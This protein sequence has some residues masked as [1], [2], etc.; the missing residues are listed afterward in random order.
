MN[1]GKPNQTGLDVIVA[2]FAGWVKSVAEEFRQIHDE[3]DVQ[4]LE[5]QVRS[6]GRVIQSRLVQHVLQEAV[7]RQQEATRICPYCGKRRR[8]QGLRRRELRTSLGEVEVV[9]IYWKCE[10]CGLCSH[11]AEGIIPESFSRLMRG[12]VCLV[13]TA[14]AS[15][16]KAELVMTGVLGATLDAETIRRRCQ[17]EGWALVRQADTPPQAV[18]PGKDLIGS[19]DGTTVRTRETGWREV[20]GYRF[21]HEGGRYGG[22]YLEKV[23]PFSSRVQQAADRLEQAQ[24]AR[25]VFLSDMAEWIKQMVPRQLPGWRHIA[26]YWHACQHIH[27]AGEGLYGQHHPKAR[28]WSG[29]WSRRLRG[30][31]ANGVA[32]KMRR[33]VLHYPQLEKQTAFLELIRFVDKHAELMDYQA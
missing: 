6:G 8:H 24:A 5:E 16:E 25:K 13:G 27:K 12:L 29:Y 19:C 30:Y 11:S 7:D 9:G 20:K 10:P 21:E 33:I 15:F 18:P 23:E 17:G 28:K 32:N 14:L 1:A 3:T 2:E 4:K 31:G 26:D 22:A